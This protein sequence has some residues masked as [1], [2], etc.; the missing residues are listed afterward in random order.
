[1]VEGFKHLTM[2]PAML[3][4]PKKKASMSSEAFAQLRA[5][6]G[7]ESSGS[8]EA[9]PRALACE[10]CGELLPSTPSAT[11]TD[12]MAHWLSRKRA[13]HVLRATDTLAM[14]QRHREERDV[15]PHGVQRGWPLVLDLPALR[16]RITRPE[17]RYL[18]ALQECI[19]APE[20]SDWFVRARQRRRELGKGATLS[21]H[22]IDD[23]DNHQAG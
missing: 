14:C 22:S 12:M 4:M 11:L 13:G 1:M 2:P 15:I 18:A 16:K 5:E 21:K 9:A 8:T 3:V 19:R 10:F 20:S 6:L 7:V 17:A 23:A